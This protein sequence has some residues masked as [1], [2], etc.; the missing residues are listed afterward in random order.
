MSIWFPTITNSTPV[1]T[2]IMYKYRW[3]LYIQS[4]QSINVIRGIEPAPPT[5]TNVLDQR[6]GLGL[7]AASRGFILIPTGHSTIS[8]IAINTREAPAYA[9]GPWNTPSMQNT[10]YLQTVIFIQQPV[11]QYTASLYRIR[12]FRSRV[13]LVKICVLKDSIIPIINSVYV[14]EISQR[15]WSK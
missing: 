11:H 12:L 1:C 5:S 2:Y 7:L 14:P 6:C 9:A 13:V 10:N 8:Y 15:F 4:L 3:S